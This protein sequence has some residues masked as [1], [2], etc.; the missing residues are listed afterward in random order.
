MWLT[1]GGV[2]TRDG[3]LSLADVAVRAG[4]EP[5]STSGPTPGEL[6]AAAEEAEAGEGVLIV[7]LARQMSA[8]FDAAC[9]AAG[10]APPGRVRVVDSRSAAGGE[11]LV[12]LAAAR[13]SAA[14]GD[15]A[16]VT[17][18]AEKAAA[19]VSLVAAVADLGHLARS[20]RVP[21][22]AA[23]AGQALGVRPL[24][25]LRQGRVRALRPAR[26]GEPALLRLV[27]APSAERRAGRLHAAVLHACDEAAAATVLDGVRAR[28]APASAFAGGFSP[29]MVAH[30]GPG[31]VGIAWW[32]E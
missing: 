11:A 5:F 23:R 30:T 21:A 1:L 4:A 3:V 9:L 31:L 20:G 2:T 6:A 25:Q 28:Y 27:A 8:T 24:F 17:A 12:A 32:W 13:R 7:T 10:T 26:G 29:V 15:L 16:Q 18:A 19:R 14:G 22:A